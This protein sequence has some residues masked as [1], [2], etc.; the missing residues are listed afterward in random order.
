[1]IVGWALIDCLGCL[2]W[3]QHTHSSLSFHTTLAGHELLID[4]RVLSANE[5]QNIGLFLAGQSPSC[6]ALGSALFNLLY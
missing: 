2:P 6:S 4:T 1:M 5:L 3:S